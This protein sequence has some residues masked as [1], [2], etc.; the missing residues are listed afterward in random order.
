MKAFFLT[1]AA[2]VAVVLFGLAVLLITGVFQKETADFRGSVDQ[3]EQVQAN[4]SYRIAA[5]NSF[6]NQCASIQ[7]SEANIEFSLE[8]LEQQLPPSRQ[9]Q[10]QANLNAQKAARVSAINQYN[11]DAAKTDTQANFLSSTLPYFI[12]AT[13]EK[14]VCV[15]K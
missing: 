6:F 1:I 4:G 7:T 9:L 15:V 3:T 8:E 11:A 12:D 14:T 10:V 5:Y 2:V 13:Q